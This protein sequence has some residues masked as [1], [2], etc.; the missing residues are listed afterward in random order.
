MHRE[1]GLAVQR[2][3][4]VSLGKTGLGGVQTLRQISAAQILQIRYID[5]ATAVN[6]WGVEHSQGVIMV[7]TK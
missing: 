4:L 5:G 2:E 7:I 3:V 1:D 6:R